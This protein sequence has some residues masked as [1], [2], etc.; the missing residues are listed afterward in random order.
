MMA[1]FRGRRNNKWSGW[2]EE[3]MIDGVLLFLLLPMNGIYKG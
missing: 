2:K 1:R 3:D